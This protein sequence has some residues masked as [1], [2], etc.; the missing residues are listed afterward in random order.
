MKKI[1][2][3][4]IACLLTMMLAGPIH[5]DEKEWVAL[6]DKAMDSFQKKLY[7]EAIKAQRD[8]LTIAETSFGPG[9]VKIAESIE[10]LAVYTEASGD[11]AGAEALYK[12]A[13]AILEARLRS[14]DHYLAISLDYL[15]DFYQRIG[16]HDEEKALRERAKAIRF[17]TGTRHTDDG[18][19]R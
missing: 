10:N 16:R 4:G 7:P 2:R 8:A 5:A 13:L 6:Q 15:A 12:K 9:D 14:D 19:I 3:T 17:D 1:I 18:T 11:I